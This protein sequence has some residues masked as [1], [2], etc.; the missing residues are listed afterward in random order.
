MKSAFTDL[1][2]FRLL[3][4]SQDES[5][6]N[7]RCLILEAVHYVVEAALGEAEAR[8]LL[9]SESKFAL[10]L[11]CHTIHPSTRDALVRIA[12]ERGIAVYETERLLVPAQLLANVQRA[13]TEHPENAAQS[14][15]ETNKVAT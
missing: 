11:I 7:T 1:S 14:P 12:V 6:L 13:L 3:V 8:V 10:A 15:S 9:E 2:A 5:L 4:C